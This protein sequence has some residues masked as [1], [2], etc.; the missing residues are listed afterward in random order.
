MQSC[1]A[2]VRDT[3]ENRKNPGDWG[4]GPSPLPNSL[5]PMNLTFKVGGSAPIR[6]AECGIQFAP[7]SK[8][9]LHVPGHQ[10][11]GGSNAASPMFSV[12]IT[13]RPN[14]CINSEKL[15]CTHLW[16]RTCLVNG[17]TWAAESRQGLPF[18]VSWTQRCGVGDVWLQS[19][20]QKF[21]SGLRERKLHFATWVTT[22][23]TSDAQYSVSRVQ[24]RVRGLEAGEEKTLLSVWTGWNLPQ[25]HQLSVFDRVFGWG[26]VLLLAWRKHEAC[27][28]AL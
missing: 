28:F 27:G 16:S 11:G 6:V 12:P 3:V 19:S 2:C 10:G 4:R 23:E 5:H 1:A 18:F 26:A 8:A 21:R 7:L 22:C 20:Q 17:V 13:E 25:H 15:T 14:L 9:F 24:V